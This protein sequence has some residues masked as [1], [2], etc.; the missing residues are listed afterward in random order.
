[1][2]TDCVFSGERGSYTED[3]FQ[4]GETF[5]DR[6]KALGELND[7]KNITLRNSVVGSDIN[8]RALVSLI[9]LCIRQVKLVAILRPCG[10][11][12]QPFNLL[13]LW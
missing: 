9:G 2:I 1:M 7:D 4:D 11:V 3:D 10:L 8:L 12:R 13:R 5:Y 6:S